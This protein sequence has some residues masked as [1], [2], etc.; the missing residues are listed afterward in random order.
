[1]KRTEISEVLFET[2]KKKDDIIRNGGQ[3]GLP[4]I[5]KRKAVT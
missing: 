2:M 4:A 5:Q 1:V 3:I